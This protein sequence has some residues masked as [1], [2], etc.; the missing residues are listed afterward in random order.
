MNLYENFI[1]TTRVFFAVHLVN[2]RDRAP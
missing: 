2:F 1:D